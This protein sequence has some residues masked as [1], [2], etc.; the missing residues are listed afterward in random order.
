MGQ[1]GPRL[2][3]A[4]TRSPI[5]ILY[6]F[7]NEWAQGYGGAGDSHPQYNGEAESFYA[8]PKV[9]GQ[10]IDVV[11]LSATFERYRLIAAPNLR[12]IDDATARRLGA[13]VSAGGTLV[14]NYRAATQNNMDNGMRRSLAPGPFEEIAGVNSE[15]TLDLVE[16]NSAAGNLDAGLQAALGIEFRGQ[17][18]IFHP[19]TAIEQLTLH[20]ADAVATVPRGDVLTGRPAVTRNRHG[21][22]WVLYARCDSTADGFYETIARLAGQSASLKP[23]LAAPYGV[24]VTSREDADSIYYFLL[25]LTETA[26]ERID[27]PRA[28]EDL[29]GGRREVRQIALAPLDVAIL[30]WPKGRQ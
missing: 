19:R 24:E 14:L 11:P 8:G 22:R 30:T 23:L 9:L 16:Y 28:M 12:L 27:L 3:R 6:D 18:Q 13:F 15:A 2:A 26:H 7:S 1:I 25:N 5:A 21:R 10:N 20:S 4:E 17:G 29:I